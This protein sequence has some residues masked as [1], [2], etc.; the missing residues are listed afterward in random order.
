MV[1][2]FESKEDFLSAVC[3]TV[4]RNPN[5]RAHSG[6]WK[7]KMENAYQRYKGATITI[8]NWDDIKDKYRGS[9]SLTANIKGY[10]G[11]HI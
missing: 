11:G 8:R 4:Y 2:V 5:T 9:E 7:N 3:E 1:Q 6:T 10:I